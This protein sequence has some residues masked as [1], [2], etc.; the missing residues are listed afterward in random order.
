[1][2]TAKKANTV[3][4][5][6]RSPQPSSTPTDAP[7]RGRSPGPSAAWLADQAPSGSLESANAAAAIAAASS[8]S[9]STPSPMSAQPRPAKR[10]KRS[11][12]SPSSKASHSTVEKERREAMNERFNELAGL[13]PQLQ[14]ALA[15]G[16]KPTKGDI[17][18]ASINYHRQQEE[19]LQ[20]LT[21][22]LELLAYHSTAALGR[23]GAPNGSHAANGR[24]VSPSPSSA[25][26]H[27]TCMGQLFDHSA[28]DQCSEE[29][30]T[31]H[32]EA[33]I[34]DLASPFK[35]T[36][37]APDWSVS[38]LSGWPANNDSGFFCNEVPKDVLSTL[39]LAD[40]AKDQLLPPSSFSSPA[41]SIHR[42]A[43]TANGHAADLM[44]T[45]RPPSV[46][47]PADNFA[48]VPSHLDNQLA[49]PVK[50]PSIDAKEE[51]G[52]AHHLQTATPLTLPADK[53]AF[54]LDGG[55][56]LEALQDSAQAE[57]F[58]FIADGDFLGSSFDFERSS[59][60]FFLG[61]QSG[62]DGATMLDHAEDA[63]RAFPTLLRTEKPSSTQPRSA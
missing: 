61:E 4:S 11:E 32:T 42:P 57:G 49:N 59:H 17:V 51:P 26:S 14:E 31:P 50:R 27:T 1:M 6:S 36:V 53:E 47:F 45:Q 2:V 12:L 62:K 13:I 52:Y 38:S 24:G 10:K 23:A 35:E 37:M 9:V 30:S 44:M 39:S 15:Q 21:R 48:S 20:H 33:A 63:S 41:Q 60:A 19:K 3:Q 56:T 34:N 5:R 58:G 18:K 8:S 55:P 22:Q 25:D 7:T 40:L 16:K 54:E 29:G 43:G 28:Y 46:A